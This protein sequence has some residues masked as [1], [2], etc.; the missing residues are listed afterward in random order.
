MEPQRSN[1]L[2]PR[3]G[4]ITFSYYAQLLYSYLP[5]KWLKSSGGDYYS[6]S[7]ATRSWYGRSVFKWLKSSGGDYYLGTFLK[8]LNA[9]FRFKWLK[10]SGGDYYPRDGASDALRRG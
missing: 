4:I 10:S 5:F 6:G 3:E 1:G 8:R 2:N 9:S 7:H